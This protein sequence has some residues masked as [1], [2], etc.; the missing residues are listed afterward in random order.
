M[1]NSDSSTCHRHCSFL[2]HLITLVYVDD[3]G[4]HG[5]ISG[6]LESHVQHL[7]RAR[8]PRK[9]PFQPAGRQIY[10]QGAELDTEGG[11]REGMG[12]EIERGG[13]KATEMKE[14]WPAE[15]YVR[16]WHGRKGWRGWGAL[17][18]VPEQAETNCCFPPTTC[19][20]K[21][22]T[23]SATSHTLGSSLAKVVGIF[24]VSFAPPLPSSFSCHIL[25]FS[26]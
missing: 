23:M 6:H 9:Q 25:F 5:R 2:S 3:Y 11:E 7:H 1:I 17:C 4:R 15:L 21:V 16:R 24:W 13:I 8:F 19:S 20:L 22:N 18:I 10:H 26:H 12:G 14:T